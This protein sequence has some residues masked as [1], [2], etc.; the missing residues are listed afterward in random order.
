MPRAAHAMLVTRAPRTA[1]GRA[2]TR[3]DHATH[4][5]DGTREV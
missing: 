3:Q 4:K 1:G 2:R 5:K